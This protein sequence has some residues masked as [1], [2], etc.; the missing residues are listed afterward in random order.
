MKDTLKVAIAGIVGIGL[1]TAFGLHAR[2]LASLP[3][4]TGQAASGFLATAETG[5][6]Q[7]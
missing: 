7:S 6:N 5:S 3:K 2:Q 1:V 4:P